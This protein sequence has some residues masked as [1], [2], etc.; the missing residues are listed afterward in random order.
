M[1]F[2]KKQGL[3]MLKKGGKFKSSGAIW[4]RMCECD[5]N[6]GGKNKKNLSLYWKIF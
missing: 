6:K 5:L 2:Q 4:I 1:A 3:Q